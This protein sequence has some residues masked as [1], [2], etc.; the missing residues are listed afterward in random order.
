MKSNIKSY[1]KFRIIFPHRFTPQLPTGFK[2]PVKWFPCEQNTHLCL[3][4]VLFIVL[5]CIHVVLYFEQLGQV[6]HMPVLYAFMTY[7]YLKCGTFQMWDI[8]KRAFSDP[9]LSLLLR[10][11]STCTHKKNKKKK[12]FKYCSLYLPSS[13]S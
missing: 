6:Y 8:S 11:I 4:P 7:N 3:K 1:E 12:L 9:Y 13:Y 5:F 2:G 10:T